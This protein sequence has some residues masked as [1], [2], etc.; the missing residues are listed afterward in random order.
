MTAP[1]FASAGRRWVSVCEAIGAQSVDRLIAAERRLPRGLDSAKLA[2]AVEY[3]TEK[4]L[5]PTGR[6]PAMQESRRNTRQKPW[7]KGQP[8][9]MK[10]REANGR[11]QERPSQRQ[12]SSNRDRGNRDAR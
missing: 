3:M 5:L 4:E 9:W 10:S 11:R 2:A 7:E 12:Q 6:M 1:P 8:N